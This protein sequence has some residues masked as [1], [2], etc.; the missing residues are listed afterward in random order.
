M[1]H[2]DTFFNVS[3]EPELQKFVNQPKELDNTNT[4][5][6]PSAR[7][8]YEYFR[9]HS[10][11][12]LPTPYIKLHSGG[13]RVHRLSEKS[14]QHLHNEFTVDEFEIKIT[15]AHFFFYSPEGECW[16]T[17]LLYWTKK[18]QCEGP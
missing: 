6:Q 13:T 4:F 11:F 3:D 2:F 10:A 15:A 1:K 7:I 5:L 16:L 9:R 8:S 12:S 14:L 18:P 17:L